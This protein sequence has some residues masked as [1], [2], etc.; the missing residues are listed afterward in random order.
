M[1]S[2]A[3]QLRAGCVWSTPSF[4]KVCRR[5]PRRPRSERMVLVLVFTSRRSVRPVGGARQATRSWQ[6]AATRWQLA[7]ST[8]PRGCTLRLGRT[9]SGCAAHSMALCQAV[10]D[11]LNVECAPPLPSTHP[12]TSRYDDLGLGA[13]VPV[14]QLLG[15]TEHVAHS[16]G[17]RMRAPG[18]RSPLF[19]LPLST[20]CID[21]AVS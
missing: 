14:E 12:H 10:V 6:Q 20:V 3:R 1:P 16:L 13:S 11:T 5:F 4:P 2:P 18:S 21:A 9:E 8:C 7:A 15:K 19:T 17:A